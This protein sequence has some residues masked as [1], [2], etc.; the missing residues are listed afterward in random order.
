VVGPAIA[1]ALSQAPERFV[2]LWAPA[3]GTDRG[4]CDA[5]TLCATGGGMRHLEDRGEPCIGEVS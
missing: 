4:A 2:E 5:S 1:V 3:L